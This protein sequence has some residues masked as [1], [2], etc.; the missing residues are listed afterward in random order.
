[1]SRILIVSSFLLCFVGIGLVAILGAVPLREAFGLTAI[2][3]LLAG[4][5]ILLRQDPKSDTSG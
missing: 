5:S 2:G 4:V 3:L 1:M